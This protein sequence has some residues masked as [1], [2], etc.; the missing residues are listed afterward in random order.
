MHLTTWQIVYIC[1]LGSFIVFLG[2]PSTNPCPCPVSLR[3]TI[4]VGFAVGSSR[5]SCEC[6]QF[7]EWPEGQVALTLAGS[8]RLRRDRLRRERL[9]RE[10]L[11]RVRLLRR[12]RRRRRQQVKADSAD[13]PGPRVMSVMMSVFVAVCA[14]A[15]GLK[16]NLCQHLLKVYCT[17]SKLA[18]FFYQRH[19][20]H[21]IIG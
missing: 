12:R 21:V 17:K 15:A 7:K 11:R 9:R 4:P 18:T 14:L 13:S 8:V 3:I 10:R 16:Y 20:C 5:R 1:S 6:K 19:V 2:F